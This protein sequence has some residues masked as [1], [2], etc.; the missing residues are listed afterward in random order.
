[1]AINQIVLIN[2]SGLDLCSH[3]LGFP[4]LREIGADE[5]GKIVS[6]GFPGIN[7]RIYPVLRDFPQAADGTAFYQPIYAQM[8]MHVGMHNLWNTKYVMANSLDISTGVGGVFQESEGRILRY[9][10]T[11]N[12]QWEPPQIITTDKALKI[13]NS[14]VYRHQFSNMRQAMKIA[15]PELKRY[16][17][18]ELIG[19]GKLLRTIDAEFNSHTFL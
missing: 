15:P 13:A 2:L 14:Y 7:R 3:R 9:P 18:R 19:N 17:S 4:F 11:K 5:A 12:K 1:M 10:S 6:T 8:L 16:L